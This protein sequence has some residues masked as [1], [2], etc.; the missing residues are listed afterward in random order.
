MKRRHL[1]L[2]LLFALAAL[3][4]WWRAPQRENQVAQQPDLIETN[5]T[6]L[7]ATP[8]RKSATNAALVGTT[9]VA[10]ASQPTPESDFTAWNEKRMKQ[11]EADREKGLDEWR[12]PIEFYGKV[13]DESTNPVADAQV[14]FGCNDLSAEG[15][16]NYHTNSDGNGVFSITGIAGKLLSVN[17]SKAGYYPSKQD[18]GYFTYAG[19]NVNFV[20]DARNPVVFHLRKMGAAEPL[21][22]FKKSFHIPKD[23]TPVGVDLETGNLAASGNAVFKV[24]CWTNDQGKRPGQQYDWK[25]RVSVIGGGIQPYTDEFPFSAPDGGY[26]SSEEIDMTAK[27]AQEWQSDVERRYFIRTTDGKFGRVVFG[28]IAGGDHFC[29]IESYLNPSGS[30]NLEFDPNNTIQAGQ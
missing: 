8:V 13:V 17:V 4:L 15:T 11:M 23:G 16:S 6:N 2:I 14:D 25:C 28:M 3:V 19:A 1:F 20:P 22:R 27:P 24:E 12:T 10:A 29:V 7:P 18:N 9:A 5:Q 30:R 21:I 26:E